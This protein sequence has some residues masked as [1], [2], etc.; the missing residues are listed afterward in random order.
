MVSPEFWVCAL[1]RWVSGGLRFLDSDYRRGISNELRLI[2]GL[3]LKISVL[4]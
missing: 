4:R 3:Q 2:G 1:K